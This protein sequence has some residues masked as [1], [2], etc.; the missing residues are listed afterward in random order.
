MV[1]LTEML[2]IIYDLRLVDVWFP[3]FIYLG[4][5]DWE[6]EGSSALLKVKGLLAFEGGRNFCYGWKFSKIQEKTDYER[7]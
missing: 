4:F 7:S 2:P 1:A 5:I 3:F 6:G